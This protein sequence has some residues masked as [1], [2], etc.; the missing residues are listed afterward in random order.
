MIRRRAASD[1][2]GSL[3]ADL[4]LGLRLAV[5]GGRVSGSMMLRLGMTTVGIAI[6]VAVLLPAA[7]VGN[8]VSE[9]AARDAATEAITGARSGVDPLLRKWWY[10]DFRG[11]L[12][13]RQAL[14]TSGPASPVPPGLDRVPAPGELIVTP[15]VAE[16]LAAPDGDGLRN[17]LPGTVIGTVGKPAWSTPATSPSSRV[18]RSRS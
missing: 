3:F 1:G 17:R 8:L 6:A 16:L 7:S 11:D 18:P 9:R 2:G 14:A 4:V 13:S 10:V 5:G 15:A 12:I